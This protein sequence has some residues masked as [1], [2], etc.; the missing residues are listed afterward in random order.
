LTQIKLKKT[1]VDRIKEVK[2]TKLLIIP[3]NFNICAGKHKDI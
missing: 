3:E 1:I 2:K